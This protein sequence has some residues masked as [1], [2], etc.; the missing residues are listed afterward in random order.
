MGSIEWTKTH[1]NLQQVMKRELETMRQLLDNMNMEEQF[2][3]RNEKKYW[4]SM[5]EERTQL[6]QR[7]GSIRQ[8]RHIIVEKLESLV[9]QEN[10]PLEELLP[11]QDTNSWEILSLR[12]QMMTLS[13]RIA[14]QTSRNEMLLH[15]AQTPALAK[16]SPQKKKK[17]SIATLP[18]E[19]D[20]LFRN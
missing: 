19:G 16:E 11:A 2:I 7:L 9:S 1:E 6:A 18:S 14:L 13:D 17:I 8:D 4:S 12:D 20:D 5:M 3:L 10:A 15:L